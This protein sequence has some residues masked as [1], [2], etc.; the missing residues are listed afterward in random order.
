M[1]ENNGTTARKRGAGRPF[2]KAQSGNPGGR[3]KKPVEIEELAKKAPKELEAIANDP[4]TPVKVRSDIWRFFY[5]AQYGKATQA[6]D[7]DAKMNIEPVV[8]T[9]SDDIAD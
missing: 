6:V 5:E 8:F 3:P 2:Q 7:M 9:G 1:A 4:A